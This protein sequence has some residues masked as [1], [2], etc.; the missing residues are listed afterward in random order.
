[1]CELGCGLR[2]VVE[3]SSFG[4]DN[5]HLSLL[6]D[7]FLLLERKTALAN[8]NFPQATEGVEALLKYLTLGKDFWGQTSYTTI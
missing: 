5:R 8:R 4:L 2:L 3:E 1:M 6:T 7:R